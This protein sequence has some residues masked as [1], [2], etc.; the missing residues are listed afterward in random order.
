MHCLSNY[1]QKFADI[2]QVKIKFSL[3]FFPEYSH[4]FLFSELK[5]PDE[6]LYLK[7]DMCPKYTNSHPAP[8]C[9]CGSNYFP[10]A[11]SDLYTL[12]PQALPQG[13]TQGQLQHR[14]EG[15]GVGKQHIEFQ[16]PSIQGIQVMTSKRNMDINVNVKS[17]HFQVIWTHNQ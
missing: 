7:L 15:L 17:D 8:L 4:Q 11:Q 10:N 5:M 14:I 16:L 1:F 3:F 12:L 9:S 13:I 6:H 2:F